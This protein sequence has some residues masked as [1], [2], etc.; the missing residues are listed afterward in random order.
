MK[1]ERGEG[2]KWLVILDEKS[3]SVYQTELE[4][5]NEWLSEGREG[6]REGRLGSEEE[7]VGEAVSEW[8]S[9]EAFVRERGRKEGV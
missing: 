7:T 6:R 3:E 2:L 9:E 1:E 5:T 8:K 4:K